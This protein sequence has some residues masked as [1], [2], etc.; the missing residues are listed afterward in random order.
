M[1]PKTERG[2]KDFGAL[3]LTTQTFNTQGHGGSV[4]ARGRRMIRATHV[5]LS[6][7]MSGM[8]HRAVRTRVRTVGRQAVMPGVTGQILQ[9]TSRC[10]LPC[11]MKCTGH[12]AKRMQPLKKCEGLGRLTTEGRRV[13]GGDPCRPLRKRAVHAGPGTPLVGTKEPLFFVPPPVQCIAPS[14]EQTCT[15]THRR[16]SAHAGSHTEEQRVQHCAR[17]SLCSGENLRKQ[18]SIVRC[19]D[20]G[21]VDCAPD[22]KSGRPA[23][24]DSRM[25][26][27]RAPN[28]TLQR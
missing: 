16:A 27:P 25:T 13:S 26:C 11:T 2:R 12:A 20:S 21:E 3:L 23:D 18:H 5:A 9:G 19:D 15:N 6:V 24:A 8:P 22:M 7:V 10:V 17:I 28:I 4:S 14:G 1:A